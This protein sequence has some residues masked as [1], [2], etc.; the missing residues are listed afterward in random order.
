MYHIE[1]NSP[2]CRISGV[3]SPRREKRKRGMPKAWKLSL[4]DKLK[5]TIYLEES[6]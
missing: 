2:L 4:G 6:R 1:L 3:A 5:A